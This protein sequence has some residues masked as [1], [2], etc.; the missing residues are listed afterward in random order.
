[1]Q[2]KNSVFLVTGGASGLGAATARMAAENGG[3][4]VVADLQAEG[5]GKVAKESGA[6][7]VRPEVTPGARRKAAAGRR[8]KGVRRLPGVVDCR[9]CC[10]G[11]PR[12]RRNRSA[13]RCLSRR[14][15]AGRANTRSW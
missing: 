3:Q 14:G 11:W 15:W 4:V 5:G 2:I 7:L 8:V 1:M 12:M 9:R 6:R 13:S 10:S